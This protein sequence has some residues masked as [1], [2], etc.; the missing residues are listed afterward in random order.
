MKK[1]QENVLLGR[2]S[3]RHKRG[4]GTGPHKNWGLKSHQEAQKAKKKAN[5]KGGTAKTRTS[6]AKVGKPAATKAPT[7]KT[8]V[9]KKVTK[10][11]VEKKK[12]R[13]QKTP[14]F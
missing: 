2:R 13:V 10:K 11:A 12:N 7:K 4:Y 3:V 9:S 5:K 1:T 6:K 14:K 8:P